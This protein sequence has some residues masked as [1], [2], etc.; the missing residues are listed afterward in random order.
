MKIGGYYKVAAI[1]AR[2][3]QRFATDGGLAPDEVVGRARHLCERA[4]MA[5]DAA[6]K[7][8]DDPTDAMAARLVDCVTTRAAACR[9]QLA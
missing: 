2:S 7:A 9:A 5:F 4:P 1:G 3:W 8:L 6:A